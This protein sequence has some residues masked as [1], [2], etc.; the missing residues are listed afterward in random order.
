MTSNNN[1]GISAVSAE[2]VEA[3]GLRG[4]GK[5]NPIFDA[6][7]EALASAPAI[8][9]PKDGNPN[10][11]TLIRYGLKRRGIVVA[12]RTRGESL[13]VIKQ[14]PEVIE[15]AEEVP[16]EVAEEEV[17]AKPAPRRRKSA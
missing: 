12:V 2:E 14:Q 13:V 3:L 11:S 4:G 16:A 17:P 15:V 1:F 8:A 10:Q 5:A 9:V 6:M 7:A